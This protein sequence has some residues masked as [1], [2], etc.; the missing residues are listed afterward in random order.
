LK[1]SASRSANLISGILLGAWNLEY[2]QVVTIS[3]IFLQLAQ[4]FFTLN[5]DLNISTSQTK[6]KYIPE[7]FV[8]IYRHQKPGF[9]MFVLI[10]G[11]YGIYITIMLIATTQSAQPNYIHKF[12]VLLFAIGEVTS[13]YIFNKLPQSKNL[14]NLLVIEGILFIIVNSILII[15]LN[16]SYYKLLLII[17][18]LCGALINK[19]CSDLDDFINLYTPSYLK[20]DMSFTSAITK[21]IINFIG[22]MALVPLSTYRTDLVIIIIMFIFL[23]NCLWM[24]YLIKIRE[25]P[26]NVVDNS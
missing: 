22:I 25:E 7:I 18:A 16:Y 9:I 5:T 11:F 17:F 23:V 14:K 21:Q 26:K 24:F 8:N 6:L 19:I 10:N 2:Y 3:A 4:L 12:I 15:C 20:K 13:C 1:T